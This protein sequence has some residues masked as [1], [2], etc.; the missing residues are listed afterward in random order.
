MG[1]LEDFDMFVE[2]ISF[3]NAVTCAQIRIET[4]KKLE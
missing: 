2:T 4:H 3:N 1:F